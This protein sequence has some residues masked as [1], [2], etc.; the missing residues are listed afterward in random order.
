MIKFL[1][2]YMSLISF[3][4][5]LLVLW[6]FPTTVQVILV[7]LL[8]VSLTIAFPFII[9]K[10]R[11]AYQVFLGFR[12]QLIS[13]GKVNQWFL[14]QDEEGLEK[15]LKYGPFDNWDY[16]HEGNSIPDLR[17]TYR[18]WIDGEMLVNGEFQSPEDFAEHLGDTLK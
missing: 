10:H 1:K 6:Q 8:A 18:G 12:A 5:L 2:K 9:K 13:F 17:N 11:E 4:A 15:I 16:I 14:E 7:I 3:M